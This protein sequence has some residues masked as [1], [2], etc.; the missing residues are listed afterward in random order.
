MLE[1]KE[2]SVG[3]RLGAEVIGNIAAGAV[4]EIVDYALTTSILGQSLNAF[5]KHLWAAPIIAG[6][7]GLMSRG[8]SAYLGGLSTDAHWLVKAGCHAVSATAVG[9]IQFGVVEPALR[10]ADAGEGYIYITRG[11]MLNKVQP[12]LAKTL[13]VVALAA[14]SACSKVSGL[15]AGLFG[16]TKAQHDYA[17]LHDP[18]LDREVDR[19]TSTKFTNS[20]NCGDKA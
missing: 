2:H 20:L 11:A 7:S 1:R 13:E 19:V 5:R 18:D 12:T 16:R 6:A 3:S 14:P 9:M 4:T 10:A 15:C 17:H 8:A